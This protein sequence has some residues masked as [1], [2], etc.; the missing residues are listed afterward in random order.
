MVRQIPNLISVLRILLVV[1]LGY[2]LWREDYA[3]A[4]S[5]FVIGGLSDGLDGFLA[6]RYQWITSLG[7][8]LDPMGDKLMMVTSYL[9]LGWHGVLPWWLVILVI[10]RDVIII[11]G[12]LAYRLLIG[13]VKMEPLWI[14]KWNTVFQIMLVVLVMLNQL[15]TV[16]TPWLIESMFIVVAITTVLSGYNYVKLWGGRAW[17]AWGKGTVHD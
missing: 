7:K 15:T 17:Q 1:P 9:L 4:L 12:S 11:T 14:S 16:I 3:A 13:S 2:S 10:L 6:R 5:L 8:V